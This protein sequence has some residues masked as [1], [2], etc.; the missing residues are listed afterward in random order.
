M[1]WFSIIMLENLLPPFEIKDS[2]LTI[3]DFRDLILTS[4]SFYLSV[5]I[6]KRTSISINI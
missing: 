3:L 2:I 4:K 6:F 1:V 5:F